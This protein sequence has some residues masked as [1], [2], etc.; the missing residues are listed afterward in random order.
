MKVV[1]H[2]QVPQLGNRGDVVDVSD[3]YARNYLIPQGVAQ[4]AT[5]GVEAQAEAMRKTWV[6][7]NAK[8]REAAEEVAKA[9]VT[10]SIVISARASSEGKLFGSVSSSDVVDAVKAQTGVE[11]DRKMLNLA[12]G[13]KTVG[14]HTVTVHPHDD[15]QFPV[16]VEV[17]AA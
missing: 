14:T 15:V 1:L 7:K 6:L 16:T 13:I 12:E 9:L 8:D 2:Q 10:S 17:E 5:D 11:L 3:G 4:K